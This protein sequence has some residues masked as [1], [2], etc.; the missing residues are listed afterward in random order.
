M[1]EHAELIGLARTL[2]IIF[3]IYWGFKLF[4]RYVFPWVLRTFM[5]YLGKKAQ[6][7]MRNQGFDTSGFKN[8]QQED[9]SDDGK[10]SIKKTKSQK[11]PAKSFDDVGDYVDF[12]EVE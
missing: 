11:S 6:E 7:N 3:A 8:P 4:A 10:V 9:V 2:F 1:E 12:E 5:G